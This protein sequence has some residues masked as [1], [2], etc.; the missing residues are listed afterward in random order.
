MTLAGGSVSGQTKTA[1][2]GIGAGVFG[3]LTKELIW[4]KRITAF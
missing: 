4:Q 2:I 1:E 3:I